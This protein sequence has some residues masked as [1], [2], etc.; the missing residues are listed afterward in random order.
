MSKRT[1][2]EEG[3]TE[4]ARI[5]RAINARINKRFPFK[6]YGRSYSKRGVAGSPAMLAYGDSWKSA[7]PAQRASRKEYGYYGRGGIIADL[8]KV[9][10]AALGG[11]VGGPVGAV[12]GEGLGGLLGGKLEG[13]GLYTGRSG[14]YGGRGLYRGRG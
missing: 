12:A 2:T 10:G 11:L 1:R 7:S 13:R 9:G 8:A 6:D 14:R 4:R 3:Y 5:A